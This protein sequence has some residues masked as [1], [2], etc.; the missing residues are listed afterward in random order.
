MAVIK[1]KRGPETNINNLTLQE[2]EIAVVYNADK[3]KAALYFG[4]ADGK[5]LINPDADMTEAKSYTDAQIAALIN[6]A[7]EALDTLKEIAD[8]LADNDDAVAALVSSIAGKV[9]KVTGKDLSSNDYTT[10]EKT[11]LAGLNNYTHPTTHPATI[12][13]EDASHR[14]VTDT[15][16]ANWNAK[17]D[18]NSTIDGG[19]F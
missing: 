4:T 6:G 2:G 8:K 1:I 16:K 13:T 10:A 7:P 12:I 3:T 19:T 18:A 11:K 17:L 14:F 9:D 15:E 5:I